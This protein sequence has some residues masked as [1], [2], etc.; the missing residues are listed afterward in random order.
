VQYPVFSRTV[1]LLGEE[2]FQRLRESF[3]VVVGLGGVGS[4][5]V[6][7]LARSG[8]GR[9]RIVDPD[10]V[11]LSSLNRHAV[12]VA[13]DVG[14]LKVEV[15]ARWLDRLG[16]PLQV[17]PSHAFVDAESVGEIVDG[18]PNLVVD[19][20]DSVGPKTDLL[21][22][23]ID[24]NVPVISSMGAS[25]RRDPTRI[26]IADISET[27]VCPLARRIRKWLRRRGIE[28][29]IPVVFSDETPVPP[30]PPDGEARTV[31]RGRIRNR[32]PSMGTLP[33][34]FG[35]ALANLVITTVAGG[36]A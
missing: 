23:C 26:H 18:A 10:E 1:D 21:A 36:E 12:A 11:S 20:I 33:G 16:A 7:A 8:I 24:R 25:S 3:V 22:G 30:L 34:I 13:A 28:A 35:Y 4:H 6:V 14:Q 5:V 17:E 32:Q 29:G 2:A 19:A 15:M 9:M 27:S 31:D